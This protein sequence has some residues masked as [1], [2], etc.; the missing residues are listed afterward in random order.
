M[1][2]RDCDVVDL[3]G[4]G[5]R[6]G[7]RGVAPAFMLECCA[8]CP[9]ARALIEVML[10][11]CC[12]CCCWFAGGLVQ[13]LNEDSIDVQNAISEKLG[14]FLHHRWASLGR[15]TGACGWGKHG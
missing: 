5:T 15:Q 7:C 6:T 13:G 9:T 8:A 11:H 12:C 3:V 1:T 14:A 10:C 4:V 2:S